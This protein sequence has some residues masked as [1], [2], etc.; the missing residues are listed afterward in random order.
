MV[1]ER[2]ARVRFARTPRCNCFACFHR[3]FQTKVFPG[4]EVTPVPP[5][6][7][8]RAI[9][10]FPHATAS[11]P[12][13]GFEADDSAAEFLPAL[14]KETSPSQASSNMTVPHFD[15]DRTRC[16]ALVLGGERHRYAPVRQSEETWRSLR[17]ASHI[18][19]TWYCLDT[20][21][22]ES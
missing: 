11:T 6:K 10:H 22:C 18:D 20:R 1:S 13:F 4:C 7:Q 16:E 8:K 3:L 19:S 12:S 15:Y 17:H 9:Q 21:A 5:K 14:L 2:W